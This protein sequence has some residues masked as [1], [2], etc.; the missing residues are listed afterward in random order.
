[1]A[2]AAVRYVLVGKTNGRATI[3]VFLFEGCGQKF[4]C[5]F[6]NIFSDVIFYPHMLQ[7]FQVS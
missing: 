5:C 6:Y 7:Y 1:M 4:T 3:I 2:T